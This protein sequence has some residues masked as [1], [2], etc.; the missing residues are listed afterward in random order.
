MSR[1]TTA[2][3]ADLERTHAWSFMTWCFPERHLVPDLDLLL[4]KTPATSTTSGEPAIPVTSAV[5][6]VARRSAGA[7]TGPGTS[8]ATG[9]R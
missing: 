6:E 7:P 8:P 3:L 5:T 1:P 2:R 9:W 4:A